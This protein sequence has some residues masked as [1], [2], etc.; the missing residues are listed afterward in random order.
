MLRLCGGQQGYSRGRCATIV[1]ILPLRVTDLPRGMQWLANP[2]MPQAQ[3]T[4]LEAFYE[5]HLLTEVITT[6]ALFALASP[7]HME[8]CS[9][10]SKSV[11]KCARWAG[12]P[13]S[14]SSRSNRQNFLM[15]AC[16]WP[17]SSAVAFQAVRV[18][19]FLVLSFD[20]LFLM[21]VLF[22]AGGFDAVWLL[23]CE[24]PEDTPG[25]PPLPR[26]ERL[27]TSFTGVAPLLAQESKAR[28]VTL[29]RID[30]VPGLAA[31]VNAATHD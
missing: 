11:V 16:R 31:V 18:L 21:P 26:V 14:I 10:Y 23:V 13:A 7:D 8:S 22:T 29:E 19:S 12:S 4:C 1:Y 28:G 9:R 30:D 6:P 3:S 5:A 15:R 24:P 2:N 25:L 17:V 20:R 27:W